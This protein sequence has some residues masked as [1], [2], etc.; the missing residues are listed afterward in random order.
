MDKYYFDYLR[1][2]TENANDFILVNQTVDKVILGQ[3]QVLNKQL[4]LYLE[5]KVPVSI[6]EQGQSVYNFDYDENNAYE[7]FI[8]SIQIL[9]ETRR[10]HIY[11]NDQKEEELLRPNDIREQD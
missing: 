11:L 10:Y 4:N 8:N 7:C 3:L 2:K 6:N 1:Q 5:Q 9:D